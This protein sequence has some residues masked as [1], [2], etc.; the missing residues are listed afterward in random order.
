MNCCIVAL[1]LFSSDIVTWSADSIYSVQWHINYWECVH[2]NMHIIQ[3]TSPKR[4]FGN[5]LWRHKQRT[6]NTNDHHIPLCVRHW[7]PTP[8]HTPGVTLP[9]RAWVRLNWLRTGVRH[10]RSCLYQWCMASSAVCECGS[11]AQ[12]NKPS[13]MLSSNVQCIVLI[14]WTA[15]RFWTMR[16]SNGCQAPA[17]RSSAAKQWLEELAQKKNDCNRTVK[18]LSTFLRADKFVAVVQRILSYVFMWCCFVAFCNV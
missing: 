10:F 13:A 3:Q 14:D 8:A 16:Q 1:S 9:K 7:S 6:P 17:P 4:W 2:K 15:W 11:V 18:S 5:R 12:K